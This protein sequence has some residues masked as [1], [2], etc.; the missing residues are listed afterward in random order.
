MRDLYEG[1]GLRSQAF[2]RANRHSRIV[3]VLK[4]TLPLTAL[5]IVAGFGF[6]ALRAKTVPNVEVAE[7]ALQN[8]KIVMDNPKLNGVTGDNQPYKM[9][10]KRALQSPTD[11]ND[12]ELEG[13]TAQIPFG[14]GVIAQVEAPTGHLDNAKQVLRL[15]GGFDL[16]T[17]DGMVAKLQD[18]VVDFG[19]RSLQTAMPVDITRPGTHI[20]ADSMTITNGGASLVFERRVRMTVQPDLLEQ[21]KEPNNGG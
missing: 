10:A 14:T 8:G 16:T 17:S 13:I 12:I 11:I 19:G 6:I 5:I 21:S 18:A 3:R 4:F 1:P 7:V 9:E 20:Q 2:V 15:K